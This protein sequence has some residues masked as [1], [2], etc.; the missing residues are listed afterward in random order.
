M[1]RT[2]K[3]IVM[4]Q[5]SHLQKTVDQQSHMNQ[6]RFATPQVSTTQTEMSASRERYE[7]L[8]CSYLYETESLCTTSFLI[9]GALGVKASWS[10]PREFRETLDPQTS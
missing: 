10:T 7:H 6:R 3:S 1:K 8:D 9:L 2:S 5:L 4:I